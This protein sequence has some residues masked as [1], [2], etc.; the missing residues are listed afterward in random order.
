MGFMK[1]NYLFLKFSNKRFDLQIKSFPI[2]IH[3]KRYLRVCSWIWF[4]KEK[5]ERE[6]FMGGFWDF[7]KPLK[8]LQ[9]SQIMVPLSRGI[10]FRFEFKLLLYFYWNIKMPFLPIHCSFISNFHKNYIFLLIISF[11]WN[12]FTLEKYF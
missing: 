11:H 6:R 10:L 12:L 9:N 4:R 1:S 8:T 3:S 2:L 5:K 7:N